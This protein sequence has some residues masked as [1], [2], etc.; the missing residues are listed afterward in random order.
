V[1]GCTEL[2]RFAP[3]PQNHKAS[4]LDFQQILTNALTIRPNTNIVGG[5]MDQIFDLDKRLV[6]LPLYT[7]LNINAVS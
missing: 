6:S 5:S 1:I 3:D 2:L 7:S 4:L